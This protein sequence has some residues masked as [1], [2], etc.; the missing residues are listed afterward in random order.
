MDPVPDPEPE[1]A[2]DG[3]RAPQRKPPR[4]TLEVEG[5]ERLVEVVLL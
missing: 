1:P 2:V 3:A 4:R 5:V